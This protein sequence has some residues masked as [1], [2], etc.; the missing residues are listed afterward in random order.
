MLPSEKY[1]DRKR[2]H[3][4]EL[5]RGLSKDKGRVLSTFNQAD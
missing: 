4:S 2:P 5:E 3:R 1:A